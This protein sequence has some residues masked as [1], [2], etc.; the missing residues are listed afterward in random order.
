MGRPRARRAPRGLVGGSSLG[1]PG[2]RQPACNSRNDSGQAARR[3]RV[4][5]GNPSGGRPFGGSCSSVRVEA[6]RSRDPPAGVPGARG[7]L[8]F[9]SRVGSAITRPPGGRARRG[10]LSPTGPTLA[11]RRIVPF[12]EIVGLPGTSAALPFGEALLVKGADPLAEVLAGKARGAQL[13]QCAL[14]VCG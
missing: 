6:A 13:D 9:R 1:A 3:Y 4:G 11:P 2:L 8:F 7:V 5:G 10:P 14:G 12:A